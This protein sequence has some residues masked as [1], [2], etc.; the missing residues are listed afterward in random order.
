MRTGPILTLAAALL[1]SH[2]LAAPPLAAKTRDKRTLEVRPVHAELG[3]VYYALPGRD[4]QVYFESNAPL[5]S[6]T[7]HA[8][9]VLGYAVAPP[10]GPPLV[11]EW[12]VPVR[13]LKTGIARR[14][15][16]LAEAQW[17]AAADHPDIVFQLERLADIAPGPNPDPS[18]GRTR[19]Y[20]ATLIGDLTLN[21]ITRR[22][23]FEGAEFV[24]LPRS[25]AT[26]RV[27]RG[28][29][30]RLRVGFEIPL[31]AHDVENVAIT[32]GTMAGTIEVDA[33]LYMST[34][35]P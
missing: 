32:R 18:D 22:R 24:F 11:G 14:D 2:A 21:G 35:R 33:L 31:S 12:H 9:S 23:E 6:I 20:T 4:R 28:D 29:L 15:R 25:E 17:L 16:E 19:S 34:T 1:A 5:E 3:R 27:A 13:S 30:L 10:D 26:A 7:G 8:A